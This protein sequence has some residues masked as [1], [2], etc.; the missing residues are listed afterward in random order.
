MNYLHGM[1]IINWVKSLD[2]GSEKS[3]IRKQNIDL[4]FSSNLTNNVIIRR[5]SADITNCRITKMVESMVSAALL[6]RYKIKIC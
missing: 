5:L 6:A 2:E 4:C 1:K 3:C